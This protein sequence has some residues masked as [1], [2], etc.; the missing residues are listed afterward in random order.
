M[1]LV[2]RSFFDRSVTWVS[3]VRGT[4]ERHE[5]PADRV[6]DFIRLPGKRLL[7]VALLF[8]LGFRLTA[9]AVH[10]DLG[11]DFDL[12]YYA[13]VHLLAGE[14]PYPIVSQWSS[15][16][17]F[18]PLPAVLVAVPF[19]VLPVAV[20]RPAFDIVIGWL[21]AYALWRYRGTYALLALIS[22]AYLLAAKLSQTPP[23]LTAGA[24]IPALGFVLAVKPN[25]GVALFASRPT[26]PALIGLV[27][28]ALFSLAVLPSWPVDWWSALQQRNAHLVSPVAR[29]FGWLLLL[30]AL[31]WRTTE[32]RLLVAL[33]LV[34]Q[35]S[36]PYELVPLALIPRNGVQMGVFVVGSWLAVSA[37]GNNLDEP[38]LAAITA[39]I[40]PV[41]LGAVYLPMLYFVLRR[42]RVEHAPSAAGVTDVQVRHARDSSEVSR[43]D[44]ELR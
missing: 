40:W 25:M 28:I 8:I 39:E 7:A 12:L 38:D 4:L 29:P 44:R 27:V 33:S 20:A 14:N 26:K 23:L 13:A 35:N 16:P 10:A 34:P 3:E 9:Y 36:L 43:L 19:T 30:A 11:T 31:R 1:A 5:N 41:M 17:L 32:G 22:G 6:Q 2:F 15:F 37:L 21:L 42:P 18:Y 24:L